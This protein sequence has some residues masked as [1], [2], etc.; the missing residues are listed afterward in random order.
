[1]APSGIIMSGVR[2]QTKILFTEACAGG[3][4]IWRVGKDA[5]SLGSWGGLLDVDEPRN[6]E[7]ASSDVVEFLCLLPLLSAPTGL[8]WDTV[9]VLNSLDN[10]KVKSYDKKNLEWCY[11]VTTILKLRHIQISNCQTHKFHI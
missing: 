8:K 10:I 7:C 1:M 11:Q 3:M 4:T 2:G 5:P 6:W 9:F